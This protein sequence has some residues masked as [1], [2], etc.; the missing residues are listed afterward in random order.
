[1][2]DFRFRRLETYKVG[3][4]RDRM[5]LSF[6]LPRSPSGKVYRWC[7]NEECAPRLFLLGDAQRPEDIDVTVLKRAPGTTGT[8]CPYC[9]QDADDDEFNYGGDIEAVQRYLE[10]AAV[11]DINDHL[12]KMA[13]DFNRS[14]PRGSLFS[15]K[16]DV[17]PDHTPEPRAWREDLIR[18]L[19]CDRCGRAYGVYAIALFCPDCGSKN[20]HVHFEREIELVLQQIDLAEQVAE[21][22]GSELSYRVLGNAHEDVVTAF[23]TY[24]KASYKIMV[25]RAFSKEEAAKLAGKGAIGN[26]FQNI[27][28]ARE[29]YQNL[30]IDPFSVL[31][32]DEL[33]Q[34][35][36]NIEKRHVIGHNL[37][38]ADEA[39]A[40]ADSREKPGTTVAI[41]SE[42]ISEFALTAKK[43]IV[44]LE[45]LL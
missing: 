31:D 16:M 17:K 8:T 4:S 20:L 28:R 21:N 15:V 27:D 9:G 34:M 14:M 35:R 44:E 33:E 29:L 13:R 32:P 41:L 10:W 11:R 43:V 6:P 25:R 42:E 12:V 23:E 30:A 22:G 26:R 37:S 19:A 45:R 1:M 39:Y 5:E 3:G 18:N 40:G 38:M 36:L 7:P 24:Q 2:S